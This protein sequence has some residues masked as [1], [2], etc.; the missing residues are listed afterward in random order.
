MRRNLYFV[1]FGV[2]I[3]WLAGISCKSGSNDFIPNP[4]DESSVEPSFPQSNILEEAD[5]SGRL[6]WQKPEDVIAL[7]GDLSGK[8]VADIGAGS[9]FFTIRFALKAKKVIAI[10]IDSIML[11][12][13]KTIQQRLPIDIQEKIETRLALPDD[14]L[15]SAEEADIVVIINTIAYIDHRNDY[16]KTVF[17]GIKPGGEIMILDFKMKQLAIEAPP[18][19]NRVPLNQIEL[20]LTGAGYVNIRSDDRT[21]DYQYIVFA[22]KPTN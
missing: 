16:L 8:T 12:Y 1:M 18:L 4:G 17:N 11:K 3:I 13:I 2:I 14:P 22:E 7:L 21:L 9:G 5:E 15:L 19:E 20:D 6:V 10:D